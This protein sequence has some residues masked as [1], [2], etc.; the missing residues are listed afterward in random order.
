MKELFNIREAKSKRIVAGPFGDKVSAKAERN[1]LDPEALTESDFGKRGH[2]F[3]FV[4]TY[5]KDHIRFG[6]KQTFIAPQQNKKKK[7]R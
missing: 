3:S 5:G 7:T 4:V 6:S 2:A 1:K